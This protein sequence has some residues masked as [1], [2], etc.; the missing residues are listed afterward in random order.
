MPPKRTAGQ[1]YFLTYSQ[2]A[3]VSIDDIADHIANL[4]PCWLEIVQEN[5]QEDGIHYHAVVVFES[6]F[7]QPLTIFDCDG[8]HPNIIVIK[9]GTVDLCNYRHYI[10]KGPDRAKED[11][12]TVKSHKVKPCDYIVEPDTRGA[13]PLYT[14]TTGRL[15]WGGILSQAQ[16]EEEFLALCQSNQPKEWVL[17]NASIRAYGAQHYKKER[18]PEKVYDRESWVIPTALDDWVKEVFGEVRTPSPGSFSFHCSC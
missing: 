12:H 17:R 13:V 14:D 2:A 18:A 7:Q 1:R 4:A 16:S 8:H 11:E 9:N 5:H 10:R 3:A 15:D 6:R